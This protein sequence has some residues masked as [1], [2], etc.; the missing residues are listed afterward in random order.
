VRTA[1]GDAIPAFGDA[2]TA[3]GNSIPAGG[4]A[5]PAFGDATTA[6]GDHV[7]AVGDERTAFGD[8]VPEDQ[9]RPKTAFGTPK[10]AVFEGKGEKT[11]KRRGFWRE[12]GAAD[13]RTTGLRDDRTKVWLCAEGG[14]GIT[15]VV[16]KHM[17]TIEDPLNY[18]RLIAKYQLLEMARL[19]HY[20]RK[21]GVSDKGVRYRICSDYFYGQGM[22]L[23]A[24]GDPI[25]WE[26]K[27]ISPVL[28]FAERFPSGSDKPRHLDKLY[29]Y[30]HANLYWQTEV[31]LR[32]LFDQLNEDTKKL[33]EELAQTL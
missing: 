32:V 23:D 1:F 4:N 18:G 16:K 15:L 7:P 29:W 11:G 14:G 24:D 12:R 31:T 2:R 9:K 17:E 3:F 21:H 6:F 20:L 30:Y 13:Y 8:A 10:M 33:E 5:I 28:I 26:G 19:N 25:P 27:Q 22:F